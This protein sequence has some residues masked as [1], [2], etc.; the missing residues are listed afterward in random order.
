MDLMAA[1][2]QAIREHMNSCCGCI[3]L[4]HLALRPLRP[5]TYIFARLALQHVANAPFRK[6]ILAEFPL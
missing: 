6:S 1:T 4:I 2:H 5:F 3:H